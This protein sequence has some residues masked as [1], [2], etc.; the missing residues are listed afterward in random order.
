MHRIVARVGDATIEA[1]EHAQGSTPRR[2]LT[3]TILLGNGRPVPAAVA[4]A[5]GYLQ[6]QQQHA[7]AGRPAGET[8]PR[9]WTGAV[10]GNEA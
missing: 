4:A 5:A 8:P 6:A 2:A 3:R 1:A 10:G 9:R 7:Q